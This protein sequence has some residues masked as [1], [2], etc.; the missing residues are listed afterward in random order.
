ME[1]QYKQSLISLGVDFFFLC[2]MSK[3]LFT[4]LAEFVPLIRNI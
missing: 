3:Q 1:K 2:L 4:I